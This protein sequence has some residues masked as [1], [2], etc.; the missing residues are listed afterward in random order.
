MSAMHCGCTLA[1][2]QTKLVV[3]SGGPGAGKT[4][5]LEVIRRNFCQHVAVLPEAASILYGGGFPRRTTLEAKRAAQRA[6]FAVQTELERM[7]LREGNYAVVL[8]DR[9]TLDGLAYWPEALD[10]FY[11]EVGSPRENELKKYSTVIH[12]RTPTKGYNHSNPLRTETPE[13]AHAIDERIVTAWDGHPNRVFINSTDAFFEKLTR[14]IECVRH[15]LPECCRHPKTS[16]LAGVL[17]RLRREFMPH[18]AHNP[19]T[20]NATFA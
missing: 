16:T 4:A 13:E 20:I 15:E 1:N 18:R 14:A 5:V 11:R 7:V 10:T 3:L 9:G 2:H 12:L 6:I 8:C 19:S 17:S